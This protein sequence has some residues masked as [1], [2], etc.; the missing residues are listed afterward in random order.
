LDRVLLESAFDTQSLKTLL[1]I[2]ST[3]PLKV[4]NGGI[5]LLQSSFFKDAVGDATGANGGVATES[6]ANDGQA[7]VLE[8]EGDYVE[9]QFE[10]E[11]DV[12][13]VNI[14]I[15]FRTPDGD[16]PELRLFVGGLSTRVLLQCGSAQ[17]YFWFQNSLTDGLSAGTYTF[18]LEVTAE[19]LDTN[20]DPQPAYVDAINIRDDRFNYTEDNTPDANDQLSGPEL[21]P[22]LFTKEFNVVTTKRDVDFAEVNQNWN[23]TQNDQFIEVASDSGFSDSI[24]SDNTEI[25]SGN[26]NTTKEL[27][28][29]VGFSRYTVDSTDSPTTGDTGQDIFSHELFGN[30]QAITKDGI[31]EANMR[32][33]IPAGDAVNS[34]FA[35]SGLFD[36]AGNLLTSGV[37]P[38]FQKQDGQ[39]V[40]S[41]ERLRFENS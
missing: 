12:D 16:G 24:R 13:D 3:D 37:I 10:F 32:A 35:E 41:S 9:V 27:Y 23:D 8:N 29:R 34:T 30:P 28:V 1:D 33:I 38:E 39:L 11:Y 5:R 6:N 14:P 7:R 19:C 26:L 20:G 31:G 21:Y 22:D 15:R 25:V 40:I 18:R 17:S 4:D 36:S 2:G